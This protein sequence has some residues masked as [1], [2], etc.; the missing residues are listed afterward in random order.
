M[1]PCLRVNN[2]AL[3]MTQAFALC[4][5]EKGSSV[6]WEFHLPPTGQRAENSEQ[7]KHFPR[8]QSSALRLAGFYDFDLGYI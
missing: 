5:V 3:I 8:A 4:S 6:V 7:E 1:Q 2:A